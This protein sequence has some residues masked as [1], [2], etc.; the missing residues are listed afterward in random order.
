MLR[1][2][3]YQNATKGNKAF[4]KWFARA[5]VNQ[6]ISLQDLAAHMAK[7]NTPYSQGAIYGV[8]TDMVQCIHELVLEC[9][10][11]KI[12]DLAIFSAGLKTKGADNFKDFNVA[13]NI[14]SAHLRARPCGDFTRAELTAAARMH[15]AGQYNPGEKAEDGNGSATGTGTKGDN[16]GGGARDT[17]A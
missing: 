15:E 2:K 7:H 11:V 1:Y 13:T 14:L 4:G 9:N 12:P 3:I 6:T 8:L 17:N 5:V 10:A 16:T